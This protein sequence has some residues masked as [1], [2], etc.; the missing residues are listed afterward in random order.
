MRAVWRPS[1]FRYLV[2]DMAGKRAP[3]HDDRGPGRRSL[4]EARA[5]EHLRRSLTTA[6]RYEAEALLKPRRELPDP[7]DMPE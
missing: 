2:D 5:A 6:A 1:W 7:S 3:R 4:D